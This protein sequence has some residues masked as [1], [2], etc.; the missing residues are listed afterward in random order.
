[1]HETKAQVHWIDMPRDGQKF[2]VTYQ[3]TWLGLLG[4]GWYWTACRAILRVLGK[5]LQCHI[6]GIFWHALDPGFIA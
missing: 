4:G 1:M 3:L 6:I 5:S 2:S